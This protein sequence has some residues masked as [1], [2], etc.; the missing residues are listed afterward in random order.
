MPQSLFEKY[1]SSIAHKNSFNSF[2]DYHSSTKWDGVDRLDELFETLTL[3]DPSPEKKYIS[4]ILMIKWLYS[5]VVGQKSPT[6]VGS[7]GVLTL[8][9]PQNIG[10]TSWFRNLHPKE[11]RY[12]TFKD[13]HILDTKNKDSVK[14]AVSYVVTELGELGGTMRK[15]DRDA[16]KSFIN[17]NSD[18]IRLPYDKGYSKLPRRTIFCASVND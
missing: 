14:T 15:S 9:G 16:L 7:K 4:K 5:I 8:Q 11:I 17:N 10:K 2:I 13:G 1:I 18:D 6:G 12:K 3:K